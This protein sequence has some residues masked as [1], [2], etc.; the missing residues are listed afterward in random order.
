ML[1]ES[2]ADGGVRC[3][4]PRDL[5]LK[6]ATQ[7]TLGAA[8]MLRNGGHPAVMKDNVTSPGGSTAEGTYHLEQNGNDLY[9][10][11]LLFISFLIIRLAEITLCHS[12]LSLSLYLFTF[13]S[14]LYKPILRK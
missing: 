3:G 1:I 8:A 14:I 9:I 11:Y 5:A 13:F 4:L 6:L 2:L 10:Y 7:T 12:I